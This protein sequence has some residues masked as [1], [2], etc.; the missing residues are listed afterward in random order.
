MIKTDA[1][2]SVLILPWDVDSVYCGS[3]CANKTLDEEVKDDNGKDSLSTRAE[4]EV[5][6]F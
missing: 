4:E 6:N 5:V 1:V 2:L 3:L